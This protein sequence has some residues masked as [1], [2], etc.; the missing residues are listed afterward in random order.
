MSK[1]EI[2]LIYWYNYTIFIYIWVLSKEYIS[3]V[4]VGVAKPEL[5]FSY[6]Y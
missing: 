1:I 2:L 3:K 6:Y 5:S 4:E